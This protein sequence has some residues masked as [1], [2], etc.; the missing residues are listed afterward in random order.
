MV[1]PADIHEPDEAALLAARN[2]KR[3]RKIGAV[4]LLVVLAGD[5]PP[6][7]PV[8]RR[9]DEPRFQMILA[10]SPRDRADCV[11]FGTILLSLKS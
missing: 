7:L 1:I 5:L 6:A 3:A 2:R 9:L 11:V 10:R 4:E 8:R